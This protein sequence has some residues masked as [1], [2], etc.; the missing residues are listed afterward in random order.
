[1][2]TRMDVFWVHNT[3]YG[4]FGPYGS[5]VLLIAEPIAELI[6]ELAELC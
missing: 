5:R 2:Y 3:P 4:P 6:A 1:M